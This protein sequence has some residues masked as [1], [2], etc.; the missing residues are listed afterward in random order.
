[1]RH[2]LLFRR[3]AQLSANGAGS[4]DYL[5]ESEAQWVVAILQR[6]VV[7]DAGTSAISML[8][9]RTTLTDLFDRRNQ[10]GPPSDDS[11]MVR[12]RAIQLTGVMSPYPRV[13]RVVK[14]K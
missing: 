2:L 11:R 6:A 1:M 3:Y 8:R 10:K 13:V 9:S 4:Q 14:E 12:L 5:R 7:L